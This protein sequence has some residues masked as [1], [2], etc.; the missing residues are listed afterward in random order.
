MHLSL[1][2]FWS[3]TCAWRAHT[4]PGGAPGCSSV[5][6]V[7][8]GELGLGRELFS[9]KIAPELTPPSGAGWTTLNP[10]SRY[11]NAKL[12]AFFFL[13]RNWSRPG[14][15][16]WWAGL[17]PSGRVDRASAGLSRSCWFAKKTAQAPRFFLIGGLLALMPYRFRTCP[18]RGLTRGS[19]AYNFRNIGPRCCWF[20]SLSYMCF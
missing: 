14:V 19:E 3:A 12:N 16:I 18:V 7:V 9:E 4:C 2:P 5:L 15:L 17:W 8:H 10:P 11:I 20:V 13:P 6:L 1:E